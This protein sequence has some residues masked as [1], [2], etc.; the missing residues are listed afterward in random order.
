M[1]LF[2]LQLSE[3]GYPCFFGKHIK[4]EVCLLFLWLEINKIKL[5]IIYIIT[6]IK[7]IEEEQFCFIQ[8]RHKFLYHQ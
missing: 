3:T 1:L 2:S 5:D 8:L 6:L 4:G 7:K